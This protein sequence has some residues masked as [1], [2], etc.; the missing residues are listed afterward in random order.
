M[1]NKIKSFWNVFWASMKEAYNVA[2]KSP[3]KELTQDYR[4][5]A[6]INFLAI[7]VSKLNN[8]VNTESTFDI[9][10]DS[11]VAEPLGE[12]VTDLE[13]KRF[14][15]TAEM[16]ATG[17]YWVFPSTDSTGTLYHRYVPQSDVRILDMD[18]ENITSVIGII[19]KYVSSDSKV[20]LLNRKHTLSG[21][22]LT[23]ETYTTNNVNERVYFEPWEEYESTYTFS[24][25]NNIGV[26][27]FKSPTSS[28]GKSLVYGVPLNYGCSA[29]ED[30][31]FNDLS[32]IEEEFKNAKSKLFADP[33]ILKKQSYKY[34]NA[35]GKKISEG[36]WEIPENL[37]PID[38]RGGQ[39][40]ATIDIFSPAIRYSE[41]GQKLLDDMH[42]YEQQVGTDRGFLTPFETGTATTA[43]E[44]RRANASTIA[45][46]DKIHTA[47]KTGIESTIKADALFLNISE[48]LYSIQI[49]WYDVF[50]DE[51]AA[52]NRIREAVQDGV[53][54][55]IDQMQWLFPNLSK[56][57]LDEK[58]A[59]IQEEKQSNMI[60]MQSAAILGTEQSVNDDTIKSKAEDIV[61]GNEKNQINTQANQKE[62]KDNY[63]KK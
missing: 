15:I 3:I 32:M 16:L 31:I 53:A 54:E 7:F 36:G 18:A 58:L 48:D 35:Q 60:A 45:L 52:Y 30:T 49:D 14:D 22:T 10:T 8:L 44:I 55:K 17:D 42:R 28:R 56:D 1:F 26:G 13:S 25:V 27:R 59:R 43:T 12:L 40:G 4:D 19:D 46:I 39:T 51:T 38:T 37:F 21:N 5:T 29:I 11:S 62:E 2:F 41:F 47:L 6:N 33:L 50:A 57:E 34:T 24:N 9:E 20:F 61:S 63:N 23:I